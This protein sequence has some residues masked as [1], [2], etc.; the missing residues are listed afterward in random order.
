LVA[1][2][3]YTSLGI[4]IASL[5]TV[6]VKHYGSDRNRTSQLVRLEARLVSLETKIDPFWKIVEQN[7][8]RLLKRPTHERMDQLLD[9]MSQGNITLAEAK[10]L[11]PYLE[12][13][14]KGDDATRILAIS[15]VLTRCYQIIGDKHG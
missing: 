1:I 4:A 6:I 9:R 8:P 14:L 2:E 10:E 13:E 15:L 3:E 7:I 5:L 11:I 12:E